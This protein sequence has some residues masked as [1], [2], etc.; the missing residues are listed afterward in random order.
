MKRYK[1]RPATTEDIVN[2][3]GENPPFAVRAW[4]VEYNDKVVSVAGVMFTRAGNIVFSDIVDADNIPNTVI[5]KAT[6]DVWEKIQDTSKMLT[7]FCTGEY[8]NSGPYLERL[9]F[10]FIKKQDGMEVYRWQTQ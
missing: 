6:L 3:V 5:W 1:V 4:A 2:V 10:R 8:M 7:A 9:G